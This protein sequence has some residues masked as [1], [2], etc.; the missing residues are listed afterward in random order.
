MQLRWLRI[1]WI[2]YLN[3]CFITLIMKIKLKMLKLKIS[4]L[5]M[6]KVRSFPQTTAP[7]KYIKTWWK[8]FKIKGMISK[9]K[10]KIKTSMGK[11][12]RKTSCSW[13]ILRKEG[14]IWSK[15]NCTNRRGRCNHQINKV[16]TLMVMREM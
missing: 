5:K 7:S 8:R 14:I 13:W 15:S 6:K 16:F 4:L 1:T 10:K 3:R 12:V 9:S 11:K 2:I